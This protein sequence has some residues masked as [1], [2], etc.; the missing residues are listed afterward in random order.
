MSEYDSKIK[1]HLNRLY[2]VDLRRFAFHG[3]SPEEFESWSAAARPALREII[4]LNRMYREMAGFESS[5]NMNDPEDLGDCTRQKGVLQ[6]EPAFEVP[7]WY[8]KP[9]GTGPFPA[10]IFPH[11]HYGTHGLDY[12]VGIAASPEMHKKIVDE[13]RDVAVQAVRH[14]FAAIAPSTRG[15]LPTCV[16]DIN[17]RHGELDCRSHFMHCLLAG[18]TLIGERVWELQRLMDWV[19]R[20]PE[21]DGAT[22]LMMGNSGGGVATLYATACDERISIAVASCSFCTFVGKSGLI[23]HCDCNAV[24]GIMRFGEF[25]D[26]AGLIAPRYLQIVNGRT[27]VLFPLDEVER[28]VAGLQNIYRVAGVPA[29]FQHEYGSTGHRFYSDIIWQFVDNAMREIK[30]SRALSEET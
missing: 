3:N 22:I 18:R 15:F 9:K 5:V 23:H 14:G 16:P 4:G 2:S 25:Y 29:A 1:S 30:A 17:G 10:A 8:L 24:P 27:D 26:V 6:A 20:Q 11:G 12:A 7:F 13:D 21:I 28:A 19:T